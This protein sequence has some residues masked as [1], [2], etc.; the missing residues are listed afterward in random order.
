MTYR[1]LMKIEHPNAVDLAYIGG[2][3]SC[4]SYQGYEKDPPSK[5]CTTHGS[6]P[7]NKECEECWNREAPEEITEAVLPAQGLDVQKYIKKGR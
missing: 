2:V 4:P 7:T 1:D 6:P 5:C 3:M